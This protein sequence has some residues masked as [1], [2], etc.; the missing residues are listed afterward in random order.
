MEKEMAILIGDL[1]GYTALTE[2]HGAVSAADLIDK[3]LHIVENCLTGDCRLQERVGD[4]VMIVSES[5]DALLS[6]AVM[7]L[8]RAYR[9]ENFL[10]IHGGLHYG[11]ILKRKDSYFGAAINLTARIAAKANP[12]TFWCSAAF[13]E[14][15]KDKSKC[16]FLP[17]G[18]HLFKNVS[19]ENELTELSIANNTSYYIDPVCRMLI[20]DKNSAVQHPANDS[21]Y[22]CSRNC[23]HV[24]INSENAQSGNSI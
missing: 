1:S 13:N 8:Q 14:Q 21:I 23:L 17:Q 3:Y 4:E 6:T 19:G 15:I 12:G 9:E 24:Y 22:F 16:N 11:R 18:K 20:I 10:Q 5:A 7:M 2:T